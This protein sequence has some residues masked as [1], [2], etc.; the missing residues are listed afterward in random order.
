MRRPESLISR[1]FML[2]LFCAAVLLTPVLCSFGQGT[3]QPSNQVAPEPQHRLA[4]ADFGAQLA[5]QSREAAGEEKDDTEELKKS[6][7]VN[8]IAKTFGLTL[9]QAYWA[10][11]VFNFAVIAA[12]IVWISR[13]KLPGLFRTRTV[14]IQ[15]AMEEARKA[16][17]DANRR[18]QEIESRLSKLDSEIASMHASAAQEAAAEEARIK[19]AA[20]EDT[21]KIIDT[22]EQEIAAAAKSARRELKAYAADLAVGL[23]Q[24]QI[25]V[26]SATDEAL[27]RSFAGQLGSAGTNGASSGKD[28]H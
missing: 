22:A 8:F 16:S 20:E 5:K 9:K 28:G 13:S 3:Q 2:I 14:N 27:V 26:D 19:A 7:S 15:K 11:F 4:G 17:Q 6:P 12:V 23:A 21:R 25:R 24:R 10:S 18:L 1:L